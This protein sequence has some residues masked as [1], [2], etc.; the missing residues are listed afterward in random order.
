MSTS[1]VLALLSPLVRRPRSCLSSRLILPK[2]GLSLTKGPLSV[3]PSE[4][5]TCFPEKLTFLFPR[6]LDLSVACLVPLWDERG[7]IR[8]EHRVAALVGQCYKHWALRERRAQEAL[9][10]IAGP[11][12]VQSQF[13]FL[14][15]VPRSQCGSKSK[16]E[17][18]KT[19]KEV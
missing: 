14:P 12:A 2:S 4:E 1:S 7:R 9:L 6:F 11:R 10:T 15:L 13:F 5:P 19:E 8:A 16:E 3:A 17:E 18:I